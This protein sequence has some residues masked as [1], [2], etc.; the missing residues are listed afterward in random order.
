MQTIANV[1]L[2]ILWAL[3]L[4]FRA[5]SS[6]V[7]IKSFPN[8]SS[9]L[10]APLGEAARDSFTARTRADDHGNVT[11]GSFAAACDAS[12]DTHVGSAGPCGTRQLGFTVLMNPA[13]KAIVGKSGSRSWI[14]IERDH[15]SL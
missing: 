8:A 6:M 14:A 13:P 5:V 15:K 3:T 1:A 2:G 12:E 10:S 9:G 7:S 11:L 4:Y